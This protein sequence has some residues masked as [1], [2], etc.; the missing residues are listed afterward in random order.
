[1]RFK[2]AVRVGHNSITDWMVIENGKVKGAFTTRV[3]RNKM[4]DVQRNAFDRS[5]AY[6]FD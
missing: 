5:I 3:L 1:M 6:E 4:N 2:Q